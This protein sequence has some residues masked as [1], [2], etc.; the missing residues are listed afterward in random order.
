VPGDGI[1]EDVIDVLVAL[2]AVHIELGHPQI[3][4]K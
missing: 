4:V 1:D 3:E 2:E